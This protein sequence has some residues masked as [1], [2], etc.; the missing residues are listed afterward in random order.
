MPS[1]FKTVGAVLCLI[2]ALCFAAPNAHADSITDGTFNFTVTIGSPTPTGS[3]VLDETTSTFTSLT[4]NWDGAVFTNFEIL[5]FSLNAATLDDILAGGGWCAAGP[6]DFSPS[7]AEPASFA[8][9][10]GET[11]PEA[12]TFTNIFAEARGTYRVTETA[13]ATPEPSSLVIMLSGVGLFAVRKRKVYRIQDVRSR[14]ILLLLR[15]NAIRADRGYVRIRVELERER[16]GQVLNRRGVNSHVDDSHH[17]TL[18][19]FRGIIRGERAV[20]W[21]GWPDAN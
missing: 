2:F 7:C 19:Q 16:D 5:G 12:L 14:W 13:V 18:A 6:A 8:A 3:F 17:V 11:T 21:D 9:F 1:L 4:V 10:G 20:G 15:R